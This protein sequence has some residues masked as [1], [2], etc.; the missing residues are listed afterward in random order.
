MP[1]VAIPLK[2]WH[3]KGD[4]FQRHALR[5]FDHL[6]PLELVQK[7]RRPSLQLKSK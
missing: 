5:L 1:Q 3:H 7:S 4:T 6:R 2:V